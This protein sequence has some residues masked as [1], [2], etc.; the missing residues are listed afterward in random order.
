M[1]H[2]CSAREKAEEQ[3]EGCSY[4]RGAGAGA[5]PSI[6]SCTGRPTD[7][8]AG[9]VLRHSARGEEASLEALSATVTHSRTMQRRTSGTMAQMR[10]LLVASTVELELTRQWSRFVSNLARTVVTK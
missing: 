5:G 8:M 3:N 1:R 7:R 10:L 2:S 4:R 6:P 9:S